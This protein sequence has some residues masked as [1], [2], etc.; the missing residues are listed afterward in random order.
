MARITRLLFVLLILSISHVAYAAELTL[1]WDPPTDNTTTGYVIFVGTA[2]GTYS[3]H[4]WIGKATSH[5]VGGLTPG[6][7]YYFVVRAHDAAGRLSG[8]SNEVT[9]TVK[10]GSTLVYSGSCLT[11][12]PFTVLGGGTC[13]NGGWFPPGMP[14]APAPAPAPAS[15]PVAIAQVVP[16]TDGCTTPDPFVVLGGGTCRN[17]GWL[18]PGMTPREAERPSRSPVETPVVVPPDDDGTC[19]SEDPFR[20]I[21]GLVGVCRAGGWT[22]WPGVTTAA[23]VRVLDDVE[24]VV[25]AADNGDVYVVFPDKTPGDAPLLDG[26]RVIVRALYE[27]APDDLPDGVQLLRIVELRAEP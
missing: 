23:T 11:P 21:P 5:I 20:G 24:H 22:P 7:T 18:P 25:L 17:G 16:G 14:L 9:G 12:D 4:L 26:A 15:P 19:V 1:A 10:G 13:R 2:P 8:P 3:R 27:P 6:A